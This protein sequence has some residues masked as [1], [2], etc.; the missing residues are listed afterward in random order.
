MGAEKLARPEFPPRLLA[1]GAVIVISI[2][3]AFGIDAW[4]AD[5]QGRAEEQLALEALR[6][7]FIFNI[8][9][10]QEAHVIQL[11]LM[12]KADRLNRLLL[13]AD[14]GATINVADSLLY[15]LVVYRTPDVAMGSLNTLLASG[16]IGIIRNAEIQRA[17][18]GW[19]ARVDGTVEQEVLIRDF[20]VDA[21]IPG[22]IGH[23]DLTGV[24]TAR[25]T[26]GLTTGNAF[27]L[28]GREYAVLVDDVSRTL[29]G[30]RAF[31]A[32]LL[33]P[34]SENRIIEAE[35]ILRLI[36]DQLNS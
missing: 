31:L 3:L 1:E 17:L 26:H 21:L 11:D 5:R 24:M 35:R 23:A 34:A 13:D 14:D 18:A 12:Q 16:Q 19:P 29:V 25:M 10:L 4:W 33:L 8:D 15:V 30:Q 20:M 6:Q 22:L 28:T 9:L 2:L 36:E 32:R 27:E 7:E